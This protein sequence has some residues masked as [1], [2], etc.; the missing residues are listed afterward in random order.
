[1]TSRRRSD[2]RAKVIGALGGSYLNMHTAGGVDM[3]RAG[4]EGLRRARPTPDRPPIALGR[5]D[6][7]E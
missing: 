4:V 1:M 2:A 7:H 3:L 6:P 5:H